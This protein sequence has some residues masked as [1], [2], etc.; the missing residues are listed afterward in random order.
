MEIAGTM[1]SLRTWRQKAS[2]AHAVLAAHLAPLDGG[3]RPDA[4][5]IHRAL[6][7]VALDLA[8]RRGLAA[9]PAARVA[10]ALDGG[11]RG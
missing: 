7:R 4:P 10:A 11:D 1:I 5:P 8:R 2:H 9:G 3:P 6:M